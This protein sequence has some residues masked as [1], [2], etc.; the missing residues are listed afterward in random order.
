MWHSLVFWYSA[1]NIQVSI[2]WAHFSECDLVTGSKINTFKRWHLIGALWCHWS[3]LRLYH[4]SLPV[5]VGLWFPWWWRWQN[6]WWGCLFGQHGPC[7]TRSSPADLRRAAARLCALLLKY[8]R[9]SISGR[10]RTDSAADRAVFF[11]LF[12]DIFIPTNK[13]VYLY[14]K[15][16]LRNSRIIHRAADTAWVTYSKACSI[17]AYRGYGASYRWVHCLFYADLEDLILKALFMNG[18][19]NV[20]WVIKMK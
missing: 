16:N 9:V 5:W 8:H 19:V 3:L 7:Q 17:L 11:A 2:R 6:R 14:S 15:H 12:T 20:S 18:W 10:N 13:P 1:L 4:S